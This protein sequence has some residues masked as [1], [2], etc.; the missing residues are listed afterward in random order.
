MSKKRK[1]TALIKI[2]SL[3]KKIE[4]ITASIKTVNSLNKQ[5]K[6][7]EYVCNV[8]NFKFPTR[9]KM[10]EHIKATKHEIPTAKSKT[11][12]KSNKKLSGFCFMTK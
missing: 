3:N 12:S 8:C 2:I 4:K 6:F 1:H 5:S 10:F 7:S 9:N 11:K